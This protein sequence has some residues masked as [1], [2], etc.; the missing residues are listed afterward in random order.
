MPVIQSDTV[1]I[2]GAGF[3]HNFET[4]DVSLSYKGSINAVAE[5]VLLTCNEEEQ[6]LVKVLIAQCRQMEK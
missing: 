3:N 2:V 5:R 6:Y 4:K 1:P